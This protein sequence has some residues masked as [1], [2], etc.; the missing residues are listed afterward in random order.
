MKRIMFL[1]LVG[2]YVPILSSAQ[3][4]DR[5]FRRFN[6]Q[7]V[8]EVVQKDFP[9][10][11]DRLEAMEKIIQK[12]DTGKDIKEFILPIVFHIMNNPNQLAPDEEQVM[13]QLNVLNQHFSKYLNEQKEYPNEVVEGYYA[14]GVDLGITFCIPNKVNDISGIN[15]VKTDVKQWDINDVKNV[16][17]GGVTPVNPE[18]VINVW[19]CELGDYNAGYALLPGAN[20]ELDGIVVDFDFFGNENG[21][22]KAP[23]TEGK[24]LVH[25]IGNYLGLYELWNEKNPCYGSDKVDDTP[26]HNAPNDL[27][28]T[29]LNSRH[30]SLCQGTEIEMYMNFM[31]NTDDN[32]L[33]LFTQ[34]QKNRMMAVLSANGPRE[35]LGNGEFPCNKGKLFT[36]VSDIDI[37]DNSLALYPNPTSNDVILDM[38]S[39]ESGNA[40]IS[41]VNA[42]GANVFQQ[43][44]AMDKGIQK[45]SLDCSTY[46]DGL[47]F[48][49]VNFADHSFIVKNL[50]IQH[51]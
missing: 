29:E 48:I 3:K 4:D 43:P 12:Y 33:S 17:K 25:L 1:L 34:G 47:Y 49:Q 10:Y 41:I 23:F 21:T 5:Y 22:A 27:I 45:I 18:Q 20:N 26:N 46:P 16:K 28:I 7:K 8:Q 38:T 51:K 40:T 31:D 2:L 11:A 42:M 19:V 35:K 30:I 44:Y 6:T 50:S 36:R 13:Y 24:T 9:D 32:L 39:T 14:Q 15:Y 37:A